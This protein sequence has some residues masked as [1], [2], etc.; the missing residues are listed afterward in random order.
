MLGEIQRRA[1]VEER[2]F[3]SQAPVV[4][5]LIVRFRQ[6][7]NSISTRWYVLPLIQQQNEFNLLVVQQLQLTWAVLDELSER[8]VADDRDVTALA[9]DLGKLTYA[10][11]RLEQRLAEAAPRSADAQTSR[12]RFAMRLAF[13]TPLPPAP[14]GIAVY[15]ANLLKAMAPLADITVFAD[16]VSETSTE[17]IPLTDIRALD[18]FRGPLAERLDMCIY[19]MGN[20]VR[21]HEKIYRT[22]LRYPG[23]MTLHDLNLNSFYGELML[24]KGHLADYTRE[25]G[26]AYGA[27]GVTHAREALH[28]LTPYAVTRYPLFD[29]AV[30]RSLGIIVHSRYAQ[31]VVRNQCNGALVEHIQHLVPQP[32]RMPTRAQARQTLGYAASDIVVT[33]FGYAAPSKRIDQ[34]L[35]ALARLRAEF[36]NLRLAIVG[37]VVSGYAVHTWI[38]ELGLREV[39]RCPG[40]VDEIL[41]ETY[42]AATDIGVNLRYPSNGETSGTLLAL[43][44]AGKP[45]LVS[46]VDAFR[47]LPAAACVKIEVDEQELDRLARALRGLVQDEAARATM[48]RCAQSYVE[49]NCAPGAVARA[50]LQFAKTIVQRS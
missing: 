49:E 18:S 45:V 9:H 34:V 19:Q 3:T 47:E 42:L 2:A 28:G 40:Y 15:S 20:N 46:N 10:F 30:A 21:Y 13:F 32:E 4:G 41:F 38:D 22:L 1:Q 44:A 27:S 36:P 7:W 31:A 16:Q 8:L 37:E 26:F 33:T 39:V 29:R 50:Y 48:G 35:R 11:V 14:T 25:M 5:P 12:F 24:K 6:V 17:G 43:M 23:I